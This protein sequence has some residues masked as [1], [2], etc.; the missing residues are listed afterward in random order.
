[1]LSG[2]EWPRR[3]ETRSF[4]AHA[5]SGIWCL[6]GL[7]GVLHRS[8][9]NLRA[10]RGDVKAGTND[11]TP[12]LAERKVNEPLRGDYCAVFGAL[13]RRVAVTELH[14][15]QRPAQIEQSGHGDRP[16]HE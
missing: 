2:N 15:S 8:P 16:R 7:G 6:V 9:Q 1:M 4:G 13:I 3:E 12:S 11:L 5:E 10:G 14:S